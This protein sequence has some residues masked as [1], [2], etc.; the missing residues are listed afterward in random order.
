MDPATVEKGK[1]ERDFAILIENESDSLDSL[2]VKVDPHSREGRYLTNLVWW[3][4]LE[5]KYELLDLIKEGL[6]LDEA[7]KL[8]IELLMNQK[9]P[10][11]EF[12]P[13]AAWQI[14]WAIEES[15]ALDDWREGFTIT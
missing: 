5:N 13:T 7:F 2:F 6:T 14:K 9:S 15:I 3:S 1:E 8:Q 10:N 12:L 4:V 11:R